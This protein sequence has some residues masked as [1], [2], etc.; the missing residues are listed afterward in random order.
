MVSPPRVEVRARG[1][2]GRRR[3][4]RPRAAPSADEVGRSGRRGSRG[5]R[6]SSGASRPSRAR[7]AARRRRSCGQ[8]EVR[9][10]AGGV[11]AEPVA[12][13]RAA[14]PQ[15]RMKN[16]HLNVPSPWTTKNATKAIIH[17]ARVESLDRVERSRPTPTFQS[18]GPSDRRRSAPSLTQ[19]LRACGASLALLERL[20][21]QR[22]A[23]VLVG[24]EPDGPDDD[25]A[26]Q[27]EDGGLA[28]VPDPEEVVE[29]RR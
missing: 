13:G 15:S 10:E 7:R 25:R 27:A 6:R 26:E 22:D 3:T 4:R 9:E 14:R 1:V 21:V 5:R 17:D 11:A 19:D 8:A 18:V 23:A 28:Q 12:R 2:P 24:E 16:R 29:E 20:R